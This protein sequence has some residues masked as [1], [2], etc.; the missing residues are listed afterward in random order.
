MRGVVGT[1]LDAHKSLLRQGKS[2]S[3]LKHGHIYTI[4]DRVS[5]MCVCVVQGCMSCGRLVD[6]RATHPASLL[7]LLPEYLHWC[8]HGPVSTVFKGS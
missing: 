5:D 6:T 8:L 2:A 3:D 7:T 1:Q 4:S